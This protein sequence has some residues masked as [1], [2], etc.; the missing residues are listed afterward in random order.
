MTYS[1]NVLLHYIEE[2]KSFD[3][4]KYQ[5]FITNNITSLAST[6]NFFSLSL[7]NLLSI[8]SNVDFS[9]QEE[10]YE[11]IQ[12]IIKKTIEQHKEEEN[13]LFM[14]NAINCDNCSFTIQEFIEILSNFDSS[15]ICTKLYKT[16]LAE[17]LQ[18]VEDY[19]YI[20]SEKDKEINQLKKEIASYQEKE[21]ISE[22]HEKDT[23]TVDMDT[24]D[25]SKSFYTL[26]YLKQVY[27]VDKED[28]LLYGSE[29]NDFKLV[30][31][32]VEQFG[33][34]VMHRNSKGETALIINCSKGDSNIMIVNYLIEKMKLKPP[35]TNF[36]PSIFQA[37]A[38]DDVQSVRYLIETVGVNPNCT[39]PYNRTPLYL[40]SSKSPGVVKYLLEEAK[41]D[42]YI[43]NTYGYTPFYFAI[44]QNNIEIAKYLYENYNYDINT[45]CYGGVNAIIVAISYKSDIALVKYLI[46]KCGASVD[47]TD[48][49]GRTP[50]HYACSCN[51]N[52]EIIKYLISKGANI[53]AQDI[54][55]NGPLHYVANDNNNYYDHNYNKEIFNY[56]W[57]IGADINAKNKKGETP[58]DLAKINE[59]RI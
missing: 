6:T 1:M 37:A 8:I 54:D 58:K 3:E 17:E 11:L 35:P 25:R 7:Q 55:G 5:E 18:P 31:I 23:S 12:H 41:A 9:I 13:K 2:N 22:E 24:E 59:C 21:K 44:S 14:L 56:L 40:A 48:D 33:C 29:I 43:T 32:A 45:K 20:L 46:E 38:C 57:K 42:P 26:P 28:A 49:Y 52:I 51:K 30:K 50:L 47:S 36:N 4:Q 39:C 34:D 15:S 53:E 19:D 27:N 10:P 16:F